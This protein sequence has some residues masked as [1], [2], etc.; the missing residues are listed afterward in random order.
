[1]NGPWKACDLRG[2]YPRDVH[3][4]L[5]Y[6]IGRSAV[7]LLAPGD[8]VLV[9]G[10]FR[11]TTPE[12]KAS[13]IAGLQSA[14]LRILDAGSVPTPVAYHA[15]R[16]LGTA[17]VF[18][19]TASHSPA[20]HNGLKLM[21]GNDPPTGPLFTSLKRWLDYDVVETVGRVEPYDAATPYRDWLVGALARRAGRLRRAHR[22]RCGQRRHGGPGSGRVPRPPVWIVEALYDEPDGRF[23]NRPPDP[24]RAES[25]PLLARRVAESGAVLGLAWDGDGDRV[26]ALDATAATWEPIIWPSCW[27]GRRWRRNRARPVVHDIK[28]SRCRGARRAGSGRKRH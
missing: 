12:L 21:I 2:V 14:D 9:A 26:A 10:D 15:H 7:R 20:D 8:T 23:P 1:M 22:A 25:L 16:M 19:V 3:R 13:L 11:L 27:R 17:A 24:S 18:I 5:Y 4:E 6:A 28:L